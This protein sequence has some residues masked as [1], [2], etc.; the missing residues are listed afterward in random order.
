[1]TGLGKE[2]SAIVVYPKVDPILAALPSGYASRARRGAGAV[3]RARL[4]IA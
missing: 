1:L 3:E 4:E 2:N